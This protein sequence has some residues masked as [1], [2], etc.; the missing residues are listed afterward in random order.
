[1]P[2]RK[3]LT[4][5]QKKDI[6]MKKQKLPAPSNRE[7][8]DQYEV[9]AS[10]ITDI[11]KEKEKW[12]TI[13]INSYEANR[14]RDRKPRWSQLEEAMQLWTDAVLN[15]GQDLSQTVIIA[16]GKKFDER[17]EYQDFKGDVWMNRF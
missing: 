13:D 16:K 5:L 15:S 11:L 4:A 12:S 9:G 1:M 2:K 17:F 6:C 8:A 14:K 10:T 3:A 7:L